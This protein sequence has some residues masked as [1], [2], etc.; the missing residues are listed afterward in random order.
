MKTEQLITCPD[1]G[2]PNLTPR[3]LAPHRKSKHCANVKAAR[4]AKPN[5]A[6]EITIHDL[7]V[8]PPVRRTKAGKPVPI[9]VLETQIRDL[10]AADFSREQA[11]RNEAVYDRVAVG[12]CLI[13]GREIHLR[14]GQTL[15][16]GNVSTS[17]KG[18]AKAEAKADQGFITWIEEQFPNFSTR[19]ARNYM[20]AA[21][22]CGLTSDH[23]L[24]DVDALKTAQALHDKTAKELYQLADALKTPDAPAKPEPAVRLV[25]TVQ[26]ELF[27]SLDQTITLRDQ[28]RDDEYEATWTRLQ[29]TLEKFTGYAWRMADEPASA[30]GAQ[31]GEISRSPKK[32]KTKKGLTPADRVKLAAKMKARWAARGLKTK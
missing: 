11:Y 32:A 5:G 29:A 31:H 23:S 9:D 14:Q 26:A 17:P 27:Q 18:L 21:R 22:N 16:S 2:T 30:D 13:K 24:E 25:P 8:L 3:G 20:N 28:M 15:T 12:L 1:C 4:A 10:L 6:R 19:T 7:D